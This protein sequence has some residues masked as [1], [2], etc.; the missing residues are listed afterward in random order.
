MENRDLQ[1]FLTCTGELDALC[2]GAYF[3]LE[4]A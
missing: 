2:T 4:H 3:M 1:G